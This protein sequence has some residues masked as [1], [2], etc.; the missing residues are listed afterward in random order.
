MLLD[1]T[2]KSATRNFSKRKRSIRSSS[3]LIDTMNPNN[4]NSINLLS[5]MEISNDQNTIENEQIS[6]DTIIY[7]T[8]ES[9]EEIQVKQIKNIYHLLNNNDMT[10]TDFFDQLKMYGVQI[11]DEIELELS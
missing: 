8:E 7:T 1:D 9:E 5:E 11:D 3:S 6:N 10:V 4:N 2:D